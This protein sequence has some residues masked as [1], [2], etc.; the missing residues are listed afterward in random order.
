MDDSMMEI[1]SHRVACA[2]SGKHVQYPLATGLFSDRGWS[3]SGCCC[4]KSLDSSLQNTAS[5][6]KWL[7][8]LETWEQDCAQYASSATGHQRVGG[9]L[10]HHSKV[11]ICSTWIQTIV[12]VCIQYNVPLLYS[13]YIYI[14]IYIKTQSLTFFKAVQDR[15]GQNFKKTSDK[16]R[17]IPPF[18][19]EFEGPIP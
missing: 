5:W 2:G 19:R 14:Y 16:N 18:Q 7:E 13:V 8:W 1:S 6:S 4:C 17:K 12:Y 3:L 10:M 15:F 9:W 11:A